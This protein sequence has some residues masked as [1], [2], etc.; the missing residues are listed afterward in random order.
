M[1]QE[2][3][4]T[5]A[6][7]NPADLFAIALEVFDIHQGATQSIPSFEAKLRSKLKRLD[8][9]GMG[10]PPVWQAL[11]MTRGLD[12]R[13]D[14]LNE[15]LAKG[16]KSFDGATL[17]Q[18]TQWAT[19][20][21]KISASLGSST[22]SVSRVSTAPTATV[23]L[24]QVWCPC[25][26]GH[27]DPTQCRAFQSMAFQVTFDP[28]LFQQRHHQGPSS[29]YYD[30]HHPARR[31]SGPGRGGRGRGRDGGGRGRDGGGRG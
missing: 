12:T 3:V 29:T 14:G 19:P 13:Y 16:S 23:N 1:I 22:P 31:E 4:R 8:N 21:K 15:D 20:Y 7:L 17:Q 6:S 24:S 30:T 26:R 5:Y 2:L 11:L 25:G 9:G 18:I 28:S 10:I 27:R